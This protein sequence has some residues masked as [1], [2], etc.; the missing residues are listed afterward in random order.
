MTPY[1][2]C[3]RWMSP[4]RG[5][6]SGFCPCCGWRSRRHRATGLPL[7]C[8]GLDVPHQKS[9]AQ[10]V[11]GA[12]ARFTLRQV[13]DTRIWPRQG[14]GSG[15]WVWSG[16]RHGSASRPPAT[17]STSPTR[18]AR[19]TT[20]RPISRHTS[21]EWRLNGGWGFVAGRSPR[22][23]EAVLPRPTAGGARRTPSARRA[24]SLGG[25]LTGGQREGTELAAEDSP[26]VPISGD[27]GHFWVNL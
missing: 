4:Q 22:P 16:R 10:P 18:T 24:L 27:R 23:P 26:Q 2:W 12:V 17:S 7:R 15:S 21:Y 13:A 25:R 1:T 5:R 9:R 6:R 19:M 3:N 14:S 8:R 20:W 11:Q